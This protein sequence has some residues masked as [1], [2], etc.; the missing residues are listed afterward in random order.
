VIL[1]KTLSEKDSYYALL[2]SIIK[3]WSCAS[4]VTYMEKGKWPADSKLNKPKEE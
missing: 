1:L 4:A 2:I 3:G